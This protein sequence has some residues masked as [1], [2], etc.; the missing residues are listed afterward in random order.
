MEDEELVELC[1]TI[2]RRHREAIDLITEFGSV[3]TGQQ[4][5]EDV[6]AEE[7]YELLR[8]APRFIMFMPESWRKIV[9]ENGTAWTRM[10]RPVSVACWFQL[11]REKVR[12]AFELSRM[13]DPKLRL[14]CAEKLR[15]AGFKLTRKA[16]DEDAKYSRF[17]SLVQRVEDM[18]DEE[19]VRNA[20]KKLLQKAKSQ[21][22][23]A[24]EVFR[25]VFGNANR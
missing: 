16:F 11:G 21:F 2:Y 18:S 1:K 6:L 23:K 25:E 9:P 19:A 17:F 24:E 10:K 22:P 12:A 8:S 13:D 5:I 7:G 15:D 14:A 20:A 3:G 4:I